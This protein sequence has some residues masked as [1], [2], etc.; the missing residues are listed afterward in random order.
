MIGFPIFLGGFSARFCCQPGRVKSPDP[1]LHPL[2][3]CGTR[4][5]SERG[6]HEWP[7]ASLIDKNGFRQSTRFLIDDNDASPLRSEVFV[8]PGEESPEDRAEV[9]AALGEEIFV[10]RR[11]FAVP[12]AF[13]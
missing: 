13:K 12:A 5:N 1:G 7:A 4:R 8:A 11:M 10:P 6:P 9:P 3:G 2:I